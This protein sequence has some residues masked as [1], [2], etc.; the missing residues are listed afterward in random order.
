[1]PVHCQPAP[2]L[3]RTCT[4][5]ATQVGRDVA[6]TTDAAEPDQLGIRTA[7][8]SGRLYESLDRGAQHLVVAADAPPHHGAE[9]RARPL[10]RARAQVSTGICP[11]RGHSRL[12]LKRWLAS[13]LHASSS[14]RR[15]YGMAFLNLSRECDYEIHVCICICGTSLRLGCN[16]RGSLLQVGSARPR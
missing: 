10:G 9:P 3:A 7:L 13:S 15:G 12:M 6:S 14:W 11:R 1:M 16:L 4:V 5:V 2:P 8:A